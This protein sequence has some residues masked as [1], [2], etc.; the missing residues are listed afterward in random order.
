MNC[1]YCQA[2][3]T[4]GDKFCA[5]CGR[6]V[7]QPVQYVAPVQQAALPD[8][9]EKKS[10]WL[11]IVL[12]LVAVVLCCGAAA[13]GGYFLFANQ[14]Q[15]DVSSLVEENAA[16][17]ALQA[18]VSA[19]ETA[20]AAQVS[21]QQEQPPQPALPAQDAV[22]QEQVSADAPDIADGSLR[23]WFDESLM[24][25][26]N[27]VSVEPVPPGGYVPWL[28]AP[29]HLSLEVQNPKGVIHLVPVNAYIPM[30][31][32][33]KDTM[34]ELQ[35]TLENRPAFAAWGCIPTWDFPAITSR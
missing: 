13:V 6:P 34:D 32:F 31:D 20:I 5:N 30:G 1:Q 7:S 16:M 22:P 14:E 3:L 29:M 25:G 9:E 33:A 17:S 4:A 10:R 2:P 24:Q 12:I 18:T 19:Q 28:Y 8:G 11:L 21:E 35:F 27:A 23:I 26:V 15:V